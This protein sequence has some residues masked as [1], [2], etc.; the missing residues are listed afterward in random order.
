MDDLEAVLDDAD[1]HE[2]LA[3]V[4]SVHHE[5]VDQ[6]LHDGA[7][8]LAETLGGVAARAV[9]KELGVLLLDRDVILEVR[10]ELDKNKVKEIFECEEQG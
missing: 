8:R 10:L 2:L 6:A 4:A 9:G 7:L 1:G 3:V 5:G